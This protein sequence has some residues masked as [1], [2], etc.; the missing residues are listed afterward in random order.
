[1]K[2][3]Y[4]E[5]GNGSIKLKTE[6]GHKKTQKFTKNQPRPSLISFL[7]ILVFFVAINGPLQIRNGLRNEQAGRADF[8][9][10]DE[11]GFQCF[12]D[13]VAVNIS[14]GS[15]MLFLQR[16][17]VVNRRRFTSEACRHFDYNPALFRFPM[18]GKIFRPPSGAIG[19]VWQM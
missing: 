1:M 18:V 14:A 2:T 13:D 19:T 10:V 7:C 9:D 6:V 11:A 4:I 17:S 15:L 3:L 5:Q 16:K 8:E 12:I